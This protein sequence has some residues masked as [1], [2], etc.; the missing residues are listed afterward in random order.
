MI[1]TSLFADK[2]REAKLSKLG[3]APQGLE[4]HVDCAALAAAFDHTAPRPSRERGGHP[5]FT[6]ELVVRVLLV[7]QLPAL[8]TPERG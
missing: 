8:S 4:Q 5:P 2:E 7:Q 1:K 6:T 3:N